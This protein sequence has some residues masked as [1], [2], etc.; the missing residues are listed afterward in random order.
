MLP[1]TLPALKFTIPSAV[2]P[3]RDSSA[4]GNDPVPMIDWPVTTLIESKSKTAV[5]LKTTP[6]MVVPF[7]AVSVGVPL[8]LIVY[9]PVAVGNAPSDAKSSG[10][11]GPA[12]E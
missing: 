10:L 12:R 7:G 4:A 6:F 3:P 8:V 11:S 5:P 1:L 2:I 9:V